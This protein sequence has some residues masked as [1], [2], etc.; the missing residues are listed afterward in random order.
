[1][2]GGRDSCDAMILAQ[3]EMIKLERDYYKE[4]TIKFGIILAAIGFTLLFGLTIYYRIY[5]V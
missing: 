3:N 2:L 5:N 1:M 4:E